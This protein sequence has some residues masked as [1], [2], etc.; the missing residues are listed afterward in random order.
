MT[1]VHV[2]ICFLTSA[3]SCSGSPGPEWADSNCEFTK[4]GIQCKAPCNSS[5]QGSGYVAECTVTGW[6]VLSRDCNNNTEAKPL[7]PCN[8]SPPGNAPAGSTGWSNN[9]AGR[10]DGQTCKAACDGASSFFGR[11]Y[12]ALCQDGQWAVL[13][14]GDCHGE[15]DINMGTLSAISCKQIQH[16]MAS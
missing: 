4:I 10:A 1:S 11:G 13:P 7:A 16:A 5:L 6:Q 9:C 2:R 8:F 14:G 3:G 15:L 12:T